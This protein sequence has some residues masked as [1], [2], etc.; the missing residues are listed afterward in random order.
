MGPS[1][2]PENAVCDARRHSRRDAHELSHVQ[3]EFLA[4]SGQVDPTNFYREAAIVA[5]E[6]DPTW[7]Y[8]VAELRTIYEKM[9][10]ARAGQRRDFNGR[11]YVP[12]YTPRSQTLID[13]FEITTEEMQ[14]LTTIVTPD[15]RRRRDAASHMKQRRHKG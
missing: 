2:R 9:C 14:Q 1:G 12:L 4:L 5:Q 11:Q 7:S 6:I 3:H 10:Q 13:L 15:E 8:R